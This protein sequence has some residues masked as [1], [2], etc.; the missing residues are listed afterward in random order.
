MNDVIHEKAQ[1]LGRLVGQSTEYQALKR[2]QEGVDAESELTERLR[3][4]AQ[5]AEGLER[6]VA[7][8]APP[9]DTKAKEYEQVFS[10]VQGH[11]VYQ[12]YVAAQMNF[13]KLM[14]RVDEQIAQGIRRG[15]ESR[16][17]T[18]G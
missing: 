1:E 8:G 11:P 17:I 15:G 2:A 5:L 9:D 6:Q 3:R 18:L 12:R 7:E 14:R 10:E 16:I 4:L 13:E